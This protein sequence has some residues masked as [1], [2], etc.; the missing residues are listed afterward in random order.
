MVVNMAYTF[1]GGLHIED[2]KSLTSGR[3]TERIA[4][5]PEH[6]YPLQ[7]HIGAVLKPV[8][9]VGDHVNVG[10]KIAD[11]DAFMSVPVHSSVSGT[12][13]LIRHH[14]HPSGSKL[15]SVFIENDM[16]YTLDESVRPVEGFETMSKDALLNII[17]EKG[18]VGMGGAGFPTFIKLNPKQKIDYIIV[19]AAECEPYITADHR[20]MIE[21]PSEVIKGLRIAMKVL[22]LSKGYIGIEENKAECAEALSK[23]I[24]GDNDIII[25]MLKTKYPQGAEKQL[26]RAV[27]KRSVPSG[28]LP[29]DVGVVVINTDTAYNLYNAFENGMPVIRR[30]VTVSGDCVKNPCNFDIPTGVPFSFVFEQAGGFTETPKKV[31]CGGPMMGIAQYNLKPTVIKTTSAL[32]AFSKIDE[33]Y[34]EQTPCIRCGKCVSRCPMHLMPLNLVRFSLSGNN[35]MADRYHILDCMECGLCSYICPSR[36]NLLQNI[37]IGKQNLI[38]FKKSQGGKK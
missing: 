8:V 16:Q 35:E 13:K 25:K 2:Y 12:V 37:R 14:L 22:G 33:I 31:I 32:L 36:R 30:I 15:D 20:R 19:N 17:R 21:N 26:I 9:K 23:A 6:I 29:A 24:N 11:S 5:C 10:Q 18:L 34:S 27:A 3:K 28:K 1:H 38:A 4:D 7:Q